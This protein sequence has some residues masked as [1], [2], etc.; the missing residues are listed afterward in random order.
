MT[1]NAERAVVGMA[2]SDVTH[3]EKFIE[4]KIEP[5]YFEAPALQE[6]YAL[7]VKLEREGVVPDLSAIGT[8][9]IQHITEAATLLEEAPLGQSAEYYGQ[10]VIDAWWCRVNARGLSQL[11]SLCA[12]R[13]PFQSIDFLRAERAKASTLGDEATAIGDKLSTSAEIRDRWALE[14]SENVEKNRRGVATGYTTGFKHIDGLT[15]G[16]QPRGLHIIAARP[17]MGKTT[18]AL[19]VAHA[20]A[21]S[22][23]H[24]AMIS[25]EMGDIELYS[26]LVS[27]QSG[28]PARKF[29]IGN[30]T[31][32][33]AE[34]AEDASYV[35]AKLPIRILQENCANIAAI[36]DT[37]RRLRRRGELDILVIDYLQLVDSDKRTENRVAEVTDV[38]KRLKAL[39]RNLNIAVLALAQL[40]RAAD[41]SP[42]GPTLGHLRESGS[43]EQDSDVIIFIHRPDPTDQETF[44]KVD[45][46]RGGKRFQ[47]LEVRANDE[48]NRWTCV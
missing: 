39:A 42:D 17:S 8:R 23:A 34:R 36:E 7:M 20:A 5:Q 48:L 41:Q 38:T 13:Q 22:G 14:S 25:L 24:V 4:L 18:L 9:L 21:K 31:D 27:L 12:N 26:K 19:N 29:A 16:L 35:L 37:A 45:K 11:A 47:V 33:E 32:Q 10:E 2:L 46:N 30:L 43:I 3:L 15:G 40:N 28:I 44:L 6:I 1:I